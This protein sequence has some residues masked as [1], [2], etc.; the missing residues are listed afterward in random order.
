MKNKIDITGK[1]FDRL[2]VIKEVEQQKNSKGRVIYRM[3]LCKCSCGK[4]IITRQ[5]SLSN[6]H[7]RSCGCLHKEELLKQAKSQIKDYVGIKQGNITVLERVNYIGETKWL[8]ICD[9][10]FK[11]I[12]SNKNITNGIRKNINL[13]CSKCR[14]KKAKEINKVKL[15]GEN[16][17]MFGKKGINSPFY[18]K[19]LTQEEREKGRN[20]DGYN[21]FILNVFKRDN[22]TCQ[23]CKQRGIKLNAHH[24]N[25]YRDY[26]EERTNVNNG[27]TLCQKCHKNFHKI[28]KNRN[29]TKEQYIEYQSQY[30]VNLVDNDKAIK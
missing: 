7:T 8:C 10:G 20:I 30:R 26:K 17:G 11:N 25:N 4:E 23:I 1:T 9:C 12:R 19:N 6:G 5:S 14:I 13:M 18:N 27:I 15:C 3:W 28:Y 2:L 22:Y 16:N 21:D 24:L 29:N